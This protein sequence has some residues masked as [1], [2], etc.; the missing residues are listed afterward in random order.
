MPCNV[1]MHLKYVYDPSLFL[2]ETDYTW[3][4]LVAGTL[5]VKVCSVINAE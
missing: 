3:A 2:P 5:H 4:V 1:T